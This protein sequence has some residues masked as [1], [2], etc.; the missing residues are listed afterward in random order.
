MK[1]K[2]FLAIAVFGMLFV[3]CK[4]EKS[5]SDYMITDWQTSYI[6]IEMP[7]A[8][9]KDSLQVYEDNFSKENAVFA[10]S[11][12]KNDGTFNAWYIKPNGAKAG[13]SKGKWK[14]E[15][16]SL[17]IE[18]SVQGKLI[19]PSYYIEK[20]KEGLLAKSK[21]DWDNDGASDDFLTMELKN[22]IKDK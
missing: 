18:Y 8:Y 7:T 16:D 22:L 4:N 3:A 1:V 5:L 11:S 17:F 19:K 2:T 6:K 9:G 10:Q 21:H 20:T 15:G 12:Y 14:V 13:E